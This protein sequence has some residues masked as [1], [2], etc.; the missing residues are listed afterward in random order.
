LRLDN[1]S[2]ATREVRAAIDRVAE[3][4]QLPE[5]DRF[6]LRVAATEAVTNALNAGDPPV[7]VTIACE[8]DA[9]DIRVENSSVFEPES[10][11]EPKL[12]QDFE[13]GR[14]IPIMIALVDEIEFAR[15]RA[16]TRVRMRK[17][18]HPAGEGNSSF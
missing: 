11:P 6:A 14:G 9:V 2:S 10:D 12:A 15:T 16:G 4:C 17:Q 18:V 3:S 8:R 7:E 1:R 5:E 13:G